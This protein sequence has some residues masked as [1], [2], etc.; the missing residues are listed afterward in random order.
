MTQK[1]NHRDPHVQNRHGSPMSVA[2]TMV[3]V[4]IC[5]DTPIAYGASLSRRRVHISTYHT[6]F[7]CVNAVKEEKYDIALDDTNS[8]NF[9][10]CS[11]CCQYQRYNDLDI[12][13]LSFGPDVADTSH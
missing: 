2:T 13:V 1:G 11:V 3:N 10:L 9:H 12:I 4:N 5:Q 8:N 6:T 7:L